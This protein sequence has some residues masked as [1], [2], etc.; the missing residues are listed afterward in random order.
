MLNVSKA[1]IQ[2]LFGKHYVCSYAEGTAGKLKKTLFYFMLYVL[3][4]VV[5]EEMRYRISRNRVDTLLANMKG[6]QFYA[7]CVYC[8]EINVVLRK[9]CW[10]DWSVTSG[11][12]RLY[13]L[14]TWCKI[15]NIPLHH[16]ENPYIKYAR[17]K[18]YSDSMGLIFK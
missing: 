17:C 16:E 5:R 4:C 2:T 10:S 1:N 13:L 6:K 3:L 14:S 18:S 9:T 15:A 12:M 7:K 8:I 11:R